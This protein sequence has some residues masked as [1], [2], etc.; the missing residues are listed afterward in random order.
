MRLFLFL[1]RLMGLEP[2]RLPTRPSNV[3]VCQFRHSRINIIVSLSS[4]VLCHATTFDIILIISDL[5]I[6]FLKK[7]IFFEKQKNR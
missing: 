7:Y 1:V 6:A 2:I 5:S 3:R 4:R